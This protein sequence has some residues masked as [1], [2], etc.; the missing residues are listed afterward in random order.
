MLVT[1]LDSIEDAASIDVLCFDKTGTITQNRLSVVDA[2]PFSGFRKE[3]VVIMAALASQK[4]GM[5][6][7]DSAVLEYAKAAGVDLT[8]F[9]QLSFKP[10]DPSIKRTEATVEGAG[11][12]FKAVK[13]A[14]QVVMSL[15]R[16]MDQ[17]TREQA[18]G[19]I[20]EFSRNGYRTIAV[21][22]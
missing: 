11:K 12:S 22:R 16:D 14:A 5:D 19:T 18:N 9:H 3:D 8:P 7:I 20:E 2:V 4:E 13:G 6:L 1:R 15:C 21:A 17:K 10:F